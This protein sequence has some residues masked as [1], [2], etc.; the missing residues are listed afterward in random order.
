MPH[1]FKLG[2]RKSSEARMSGIEVAGLVLG[3][4]PLLIEALKQYEVVKSQVSRWRQIQ[5][6]YIDCKDEIEFQQLYYEDNL[7]ELLNNS[8]V[9]ED[10]VTDLIADPKSEYWKNHSVLGLLESQF[11]EPY[12]KCL[13]SLA[14][15][16]NQLRHELATDSSYVQE[17]LGNTVGFLLYLTWPPS[18]IDD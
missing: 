7:R 17:K 5:V 10:I 12:I 2:T 8:A 3:A 1:S 13:N 4:F 14:Q 11:A 16:M 6:E 9:D 18:L 15:I